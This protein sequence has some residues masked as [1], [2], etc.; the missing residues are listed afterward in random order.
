MPQGTV[1]VYPLFLLLLHN[2]GTPQQITQSW[3]FTGCQLLSQLSVQ[4]YQ[5]ITGQLIVKTCPLE[6]AQ[7]VMLA[8]GTPIFL[9]T[10]REG[11]MLQLKHNN[12]NI[13]TL[14]NK[15]T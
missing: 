12:D 15:E 11:N 14:T 7:C 10:K 2:H 6:H 13:M 5:P 4:S 3:L 9:K 1:Q 8:V